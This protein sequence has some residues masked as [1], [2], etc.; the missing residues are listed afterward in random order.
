MKVAVVGAGPNGL[1]ASIVLAAA[2]AKVTLF[3]RRDDVGGGLN[4]TELTLPGFRHDACASV[5]SLGRVSPVLQALPLARYGVSWVQPQVPLAHPMDDGTAAC[6]HSDLNAAAIGLNGD[7]RQWRHLYGPVVKHWSALVDTCL[8]PLHWPTRTA[9]SLHF[10]RYAVQPGSRVARLFRTLAGQSLFTGLAGHGMARLSQW[11]SAAAGLVLGAAAH[12]GG[13]PFVRGGT[14]ALAMALQELALELDVRIETG[15]PIDRWSDLREYPVKVLNMGPHRTS[16]LAAP[17]LEDKSVRR[18][19]A[20]RYGVGICKVD[21]ALRQPVPWTSEE[22][23][24]AGTVHVGGCTAEIEDALV[25][26]WSGQLAERPFV[27]A[28]QPT[29]CDDSRAPS[30][31]HVL[32]A[33][34][35]VPL[36]SDADASASIEA[37][38]ARFAPGFSDVV[39]RRH[40]RTACA[41]AAYNPNYVGGDINGGQQDVRQLWRRPITWRDP[42][43]LPAQGL[44]LCSSSTPPG[45]GVHGLCGF[46]AA[47]SVLRREMGL[48]WSLPHFAT[49]LNARLGA[50]AKMP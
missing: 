8:G 31:Q 36:N 27:V 41:W 17:V 14:R 50:S 43:R 7:G 47:R 12:K 23:R 44:Y 37:Q 39:L 3:E 35:F 33:Y 34:C 19:R 6:L 42:Y 22:C 1:V 18:L 21:Y 45:G 9:G 2:G 32:G 30:G 38:I 26:V 10:G 5:M 4:T 25:R 46:H 11:T 40:V 16:E 28:V 15:A 13:W 24:Q 20:Y 48:Q 49:A 29:V